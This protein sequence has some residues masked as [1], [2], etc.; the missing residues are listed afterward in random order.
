MADESKDQKQPGRAGS[1][2]S[3]GELRAALTRRDVRGRP[4][5]VYGILGIGV[6]TLVVL[7]LVIYFWSADRDRPEQP[8]CTTISA[9]R[10][11]ETIREGEVERLTLVY[12]GSVDFATERTWGPVQ[13]RI[14]YLDGQ[15]ANLPQGLVNQTAVLAILGTIAFYNQTTESAQV[16]ILYTSLID[17][18]PLL[19]T[20]PTP[21][22]TDTPPTAPPVETET[23]ATPVAP[24]TEAPTPT[25][26]ETPATPAATPATPQTGATRTPD[27]T[28]SATP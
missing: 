13:A 23:P 10:A 21:V 1:G 28:P 2:R 24:P 17:L 26:M 11:E 19:F 14:D 5:A 12:D 7:M 15:C 25:P 9:D 20:T 4:L 16:E 22:P 6:A 3:F 27:S 18:D 8:I